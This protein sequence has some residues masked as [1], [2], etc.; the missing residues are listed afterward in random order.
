MSIDVPIAITDPRRIAWPK[1]C[2]RCGSPYQLISLNMA[3]VRDIARRRE[4]ESAIGYFFS[5]SGAVASE[6][7]CVPVSMCVRHAR[8]NQVG[9]ALLRHDG[10]PS[11]LRKAIYAFFFVTVAFACTA[12]DAGDSVIDMARQQPRGMLGI[13]ALGIFGIPALAWARNVAWVRPI[14]LDRKF[15]TAT[16]RFRDVAYAEEFK[17]MN[18]GATTNPQVTRLP[19]WMRPS[20]REAVFTGLIALFM[21][22]IV[23]LLLGILFS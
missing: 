5:Q 13:F 21:L 19:G 17:Q 7:V 15:L 3:F 1:R 6:V 10:L 23:L 22:P 14:R 20:L 9:G 12:F 8:A 11:G 16:I 2:P 4:G 18:R